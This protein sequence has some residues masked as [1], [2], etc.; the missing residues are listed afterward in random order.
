MDAIVREE[1]T[2]LERVRD[3]LAV[4]RPSRPPPIEDYEEQLISL[5]DQI[6]SAHLEDVPA[7]EQQMQRIAGVAQRRAAAS[8]VE[9]VDPRSPYF[10]H[11]RLRE[12]GRPDRAVLIG[13]TT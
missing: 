8:E 10:G 3:H 13:K 4:Q 1:L 6:A 7:L 11:L 5:R 12:Q 9:P 2:L